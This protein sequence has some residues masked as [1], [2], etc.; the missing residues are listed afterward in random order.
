MTEHLYD[1]AGT[2]ITFRRSDTDK[3]LFD[4]DGNWIGWLP[5]GDLDVHD[6]DGAYLGTITGNRLLRLANRPFRGLPGPPGLPGLPG[7]PELP[8]LVGPI[9]LPP[10]AQ[11]IPKRMISQFQ[12]L[13]D[14]RGEW[15]AFRVGEMV[16][17]ADCDWIG[18][19][20]ID[21]T[22]VVTPAGDYLG[23]IIDQSDRL[24]RR[25]TPPGFGRPGRP[26][27]RAPVTLTADMTDLGGD[28]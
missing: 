19:L 10:G 21:D 28:A 6:T 22:T 23:T 20:P 4:A 18:W 15:I 27:R 1:S 3:Y 7:L 26:G 9:A 17:S 16:F 14:S 5:Y 13:F 12:Y 11:D 24:L 25:R 8:G 2:F